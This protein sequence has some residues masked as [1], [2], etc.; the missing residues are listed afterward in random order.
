MRIRPIGG[1]VSVTRSY[2]P[3][4]CG[5]AESTLFRVSTTINCSGNSRGKEFIISDQEWAP[6][7]FDYVLFNGQ[8]TLENR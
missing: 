8:G 3:D 2:L 7:I 5:G 1:D 6:A 4:G